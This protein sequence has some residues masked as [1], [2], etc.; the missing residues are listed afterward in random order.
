MQGEEDVVS[1]D[2]RH[3]ASHRLPDF[4]CFDKSNVIHATTDSLSDAGSNTPVVAIYCQDDHLYRFA[5]RATICKI[6]GDYI[7][8]PDVVNLTICLLL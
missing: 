7:T 3:D 8:I 6:C 4:N 2:G 1:M 5:Y